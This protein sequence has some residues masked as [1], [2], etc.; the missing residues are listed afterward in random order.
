[1]FVGEI[2]LVDGFTDTLSEG[3]PPLAVMPVRFP[4]PS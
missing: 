1:M 2:W 3:A 4:K